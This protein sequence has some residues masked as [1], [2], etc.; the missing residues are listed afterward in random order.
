MFCCCT[1]RVPVLSSS[2]CG[3]THA[4]GSCPDSE[5]VD[6]TSNVNGRVGGSVGVRACKKTCP[7]ITIHRGAV[8]TVRARALFFGRKSQACKESTHQTPLDFQLFPKKR[9]IRSMS[10]PWRSPCAFRSSARSSSF[11]AYAIMPDTRA[12]CARASV[13]WLTGNQ[14]PK[15]TS[16]LFL[17]A[18]LE[19]FPELDTLGWIFGTNVMLYR[20]HLPES[21]SQHYH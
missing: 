13:A 12:S 5:M 15:L 14:F 16:T 11:V 2:A 6:T 18:A 4:G 7:P 10:G 17:V 8:C 1:L 9:T 19:S 20:L 3:H 21:A